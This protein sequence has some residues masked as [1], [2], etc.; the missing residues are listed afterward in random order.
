MITALRD[1]RTIELSS[2]TS[3]RDNVSVK[4]DDSS[5]LAMLRAFCQFMVLCETYSE[6][7]DSSCARSSTVCYVSAHSKR[8]TRPLPER[9]PLSAGS[10]SL[11][12]HQVDNTPYPLLI[13]QDGKIYALE[14]KKSASPSRDVQRQFSALEKLGLPVG[15]GGVICLALDT[16]PLGERAV[17]I[18]VGAL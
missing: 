16:L 7:D 9:F 2:R 6:S 17:T 18:P 12:F 13:V 10:R 14:F 4:C 5:L 8:G 11:H 15:P 3:L 1:M